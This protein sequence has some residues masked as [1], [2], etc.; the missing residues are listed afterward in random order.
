MAA[1]KEAPKRPGRPP[2]DKDGPTT[3]RVTLRLTRADRAA[4]DAL[5]AQEQPAANRLG[6]TLSAADV[7][8]LA[9][10]RAAA[11]LLAQAS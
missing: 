7:L 11:P 1:R 8:R 4:L 3:E 5:L 2:K 9:L 10:R 6:L